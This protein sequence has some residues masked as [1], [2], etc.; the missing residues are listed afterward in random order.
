MQSVVFRH[1]GS[2]IERRRY[3]ALLDA[4]ARLRPWCGGRVL[5]FGASFAVSMLA[6]REI[7]IEDVD[8]V[9]VQGSRVT[10]G[11]LMLRE[12]G[13][14]PNRLLHVPETQYLPY[15]SATFDTVLAN[16]VLEH[17]PQPRAPYL[18]E[19]WR[20]L[21]PGGHLIVTETPNPY[22]PFDYHTTHLWW[23]PWLPSRL[24]RWYAIWRGRFRPDKAWA[25]SGWRGLGYY[26]L[27]GALP[28]RSFD[29]VHEQSRLRHRLLRRLHLPASLLDP[30]PVWIVRK[31]G[32]PEELRPVQSAPARPAILEASEPVLQPAEVVLGQQTVSRKSPELSGQPGGAGK[33]SSPSGSRRLFQ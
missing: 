27:V 2:D 4:F 5:D 6:L 31:T 24:A 17:I 8:G 29:V 25:F 1:I 7:G 20:V 21:K 10:L 19:L 30:Y 33:W 23:V 18:K 9:E 32:H 22:L 11:R 16:A 15:P 14:D 28:R 12:A 26:E 13:A 3:V